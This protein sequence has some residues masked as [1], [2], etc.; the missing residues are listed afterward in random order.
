[1]ERQGYGNYESLDPGLLPN[2]YLAYRTSLSEGTEVFHSNVRQRFEA[3]DLEIVS[4]MRQWADYA[5][6]ARQAL[7]ARDYDRLHEL[8]N[9]NFDLRAS[10]YRISEG[11]LEMIRT[12]R[13]LGATSNFA[14]SGGAI[15]GTYPDPATYQRLV[16][17]FA[18]LGIG[19][20][21][22]GFLIGLLDELGSE[23]TIQSAGDRL[24][25]VTV[26]EFLD[27]LLICRGVRIVGVIVIRCD[28]AFR[29]VE[30]QG[31][32][33]VSGGVHEKWKLLVEVIRL[34]SLE[35]GHTVTAPGR[36]DEA[37]KV[38]RI[39]VA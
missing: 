35:K 3:G 37:V 18:R 24:A 27:E 19:V 8:I 20:D 30:A 29:A 1:M 9:A 5:S 12:S 28:H 14:G 33:T 36:H 7:L 4:A 13:R 39:Y 26:G 6:E 2:I 38:G 15:V 25:L 34:G 11:N 22:A 23:I 10:I 31:L 17:E 16:E 21:L 32:S